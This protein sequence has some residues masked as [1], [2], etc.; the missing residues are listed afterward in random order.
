[1]GVR[2]KKS[3]ARSVCSMGRSQAWISVI[4][5]FLGA[6]LF[7]Y[8]YV[9]AIPYHSASLVLAMSAALLAALLAVG[10]CVDHYLR[11]IFRGPLE[12]SRR[13]GIAVGVAGATAVALWVIGLFLR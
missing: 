9:E 4:V 7:I 13:R 2:Q 1:M 8:R 3:T 5:M 11:V 12:V 6:A 10:L